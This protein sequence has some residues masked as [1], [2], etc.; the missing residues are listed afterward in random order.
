MAI[1]KLKA[2]Y[3][4][5]HPGAKLKRPTPREQTPSLAAAPSADLLAALAAEAA[6]EEGE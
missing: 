6:D 1:H 2:I 5:T 4:A 3:E